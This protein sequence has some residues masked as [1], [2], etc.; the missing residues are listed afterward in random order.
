MKHHPF[1]KN[2]KS[3]VEERDSKVSKK[4][5]KRD[6][7]C[8][9]K[10]QVE[11][12]ETSLKKTP[13]LSQE[14]TGSFFVTQVFAENLIYQRFSKLHFPKCHISFSSLLFR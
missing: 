1:F 10:T 7:A 4:S 6:V 8:S 9:A 14:N 3:Q 12:E 13:E 11:K 5:M 2:L